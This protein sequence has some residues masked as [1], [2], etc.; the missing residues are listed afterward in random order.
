MIARIV[1]V[2]DRPEG[3]RLFRDLPSG[4]PRWAERT[5]PLL[6]FLREAPRTSRDMR[7]WATRTGYGWPET[8]QQLDWLCLEGLA[9]GCA[10]EG[11]RATR[12]VP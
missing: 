10:R 3:D 2:R 4:D 6:A 7:T 8:Q 11:W 1:P 9:I 5:A 12:G